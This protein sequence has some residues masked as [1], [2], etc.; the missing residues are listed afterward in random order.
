[1]YRSL[2][3]K[4]AANA[5]Q[6]S[7]WFSS[8]PTMNLS[9]LLLIASLAVSSAH[10]APAPGASEPKRFAVVAGANGSAIRVDTA[11]GKAWRLAQLNA[12][13][14][15]WVPI[16]ETVV[17]AATGAVKVA[18]RVAPSGAPPRK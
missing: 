13:V 18:E 8:L 11:T 4:Q 12:D 10:D 2:F 6:Q 1:M 7:D 5:M 16:S 9:A 15:G 17:D 3:E 14:W